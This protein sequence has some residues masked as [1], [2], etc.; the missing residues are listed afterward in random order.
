[1]PERMNDAWVKVMYYISELITTNGTSTN[2]FT[3]ESTSGNWIRFFPRLSQGNFS[4]ITRTGDSGI[5]FSEG[6]HNTGGL[7]IA[8]WNNQYAGIRINNLGHVG[9]AEFNPQ[10]RL[11]VARDG[12]S[13]DNTTA[14]TAKF[15]SGLTNGAPDVLIVDKDNSSSRAALQVKGAGGSKNILFAASN[16]NL[17][18]GMVNPTAGVEIWKDTIKLASSSNGANTWFPYTD[19]RVYITGNRDL[20]GGGDT[21]LRSYSASGGY[22]EKFRIEGD[23]GNVGIGTTNPTHKLSVNGTI[24]AKEVIVE[25]G[26]S[27]YVFEDDYRLA[28]LAEVEAHIT[29]HGHLPG[30]PSATEIE[31][32]GAKLSELVTLQMAKIEELTLHLIE[33]EK[34]LEEQAAEIAEVRGSNVQLS[35][36][37]SDLRRSNAQILQRLIALEN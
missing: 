1:M 28:P 34:Q 13:G 24:R 14:R 9:V 32:N 33:K 18:V 29:A 4:G 21:I 26:W 19:G 2:G 16:G 17:G 7:T 35:T 6:S 20:G 12:R 27:D 11:H 8:P 3:A 37:L 5:I 25:S 22:S 36:D 31:Q 10:A 30:I 15:E 23:T